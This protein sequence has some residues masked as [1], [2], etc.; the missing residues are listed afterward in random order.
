MRNTVPLKRAAR[1]LIASLLAAMI[2]L[3][4]AVTTPELAIAQ[5]SYY[6][7][8]VFQSW[9]PVPGPC[10]LWPID[11]ADGDGSYTVS[12][13]V[14]ARANDYELQERWEA[15]DWFTAYLGSATSVD[16]TSRPAGQYTYRCR[17]RNSWGEG[18]GSNEVT[19]VVQGTT[20]GT[21]SRP[22]CSSVNAGGQSKV[23]VINDCP[24]AL[25][26]DFTGPQPMTMQLP[27]C[28]VCH[29]Y[30]FIG[31]FFC[32]TSNRPV[33]EQQLA[34]GNYRVFVTVQDPS[35]RPYVGMWSLQGDCR[36]SM[37]FYIVSSW[38]AGAGGRSLLVPGSCN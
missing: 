13:A 17:G 38:S 33:Q 2:C 20:P 15:Q 18:V 34:P 14:A 35:I 16:L 22:S 19:V 9:P 27:Q 29:V 26:L 25:Y 1:W 28:G 37:C 32:P 7:P 10:S 31:P 4:P 12:W 30:S 6:L 11:N 8:V 5:Q 3:V 24:Y 36:Y 23:K 21:V